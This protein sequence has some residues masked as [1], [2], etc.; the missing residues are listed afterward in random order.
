MGGSKM[1]VRTNVT[2]GKWSPT[3]VGLAVLLGVLVV[4]VPV[5]LQGFQSMSFFVRVLGVIGI[6][7][8]LALGLN[9]VVGYAGL[10]DLGYVAFYAMGAYTS[11]L[12]GGQ[13]VKM[14]SVIG[15]V[16]LRD[17]LTSAQFIFMLP[18]AALVAALTGLALGTP[19][20]RLRGDYLAI[21]TLGF[22]EI[23]RILA[24]N[25]F[26]GLTNGAAGLMAPIA[27]PLGLA[28]LQ[29]VPISIPAIGFDFVFSVNLYWYYIVLLLIVLAVFVVRRLDNSRLGRAWVAMREDEVA[30]SSVGI[31]IMTSK[32][33]A[34][35]L[36]A[37]WGGLAGVVFANFQGFV[38]PESF[39][40][41][42]SVFIVTMVV[43]GGM[44]SIPGV[45]V[46]AA[47]I[48]GIPEMIR[49]VAQSPLLSGVLDPS[50]ASTI[51]GYRYLVFGLL[52]VIMMAVRP[53]GMIPSTRR[54]QELR[55]E[56]EKVLEEENQALWDVEHNP[57]VDGDSDA[58]HDH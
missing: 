23:V 20:L 58:D 43:L 5:L 22:G 45:I 48:A 51:S 21:V 16:G 47:L 28:A 25:N 27:Q 55:P 32:L 29:T 30:A 12:V 7:V 17:F 40:F 11:V 37:L 19:V 36:G 39:T 42:E 56:D 8:V 6:Y 10:L 33:W 49:G 3:K 34:F 46:G 24:T 2:S 35:A 54:A 31:N 50:V 15:N 53:Q 26:M 41:M 52:M 4:F 14:V 18:V 38:S 1:D 9:I 44:G 13:F 57:D